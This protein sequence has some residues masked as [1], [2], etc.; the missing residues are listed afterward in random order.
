H[1]GRDGVSAQPAVA[2]ADGRGR[3]QERARAAAAVD[4]GPGSGCGGQRRG[5]PGP[6]VHHPD[7]SDPAVQVAKGL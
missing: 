3:H 4:A 7:G 5:E 2:A 1:C 6:A